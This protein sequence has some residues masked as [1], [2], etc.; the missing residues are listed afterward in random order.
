MILVSCL[1]LNETLLVKLSSMCSYVQVPTS[2]K[3][4]VR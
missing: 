1:E 3:S 4:D 2:F